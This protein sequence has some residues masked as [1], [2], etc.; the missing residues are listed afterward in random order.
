MGLLAGIT[1]GGS[2]ARTCEPTGIR[3]QVILRHALCANGG[4]ICDIAKD[5]KEKQGRR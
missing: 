3:Y 5:G 2:K 1:W 4:G